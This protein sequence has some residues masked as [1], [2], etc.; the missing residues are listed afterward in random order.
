MPITT[1]STN[2]LNQITIPSSA[3]TN[4][5]TVGKYDPLL[6]GIVGWWKLDDAS[7]TTAT[8]SSGQMNN[9][10]ITG[11]V[12]WTTGHL[13][14]AL[15]FNGSDTAVNVGTPSILN[16]THV[17]T[18]SCWVKYD[19]TAAAG[20]GKWPM[21]LGNG[22]WTNDLNGYMLALNSTAGSEGQVIFQ[23]LNASSGI[24]VNSTLQ[25]GDNT[26]HHICGTWD[27]TNLTLYVNGTSVGTTPQ[28]IDAVSGVNP[29]VMGRNALAA[30]SFYN[31]V[32][33][34]VRVYNRALSSTEVAALAAM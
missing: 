8:D 30:N 4:Q 27:G 6:S 32:I 1:S 33:D 26:W 19:N 23:I 25:Y 29:F 28:T 2:T 15:I 16:L 21:I 5:I 31:G 13:N 10:S 7:G 9:G 18:I 11:T 3:T 17:G 22:D 14:G 12:S 20:S 24:F 34:D